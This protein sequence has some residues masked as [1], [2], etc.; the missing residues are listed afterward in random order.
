M[1]VIVIGA[2]CI[3]KDLDEVV[4]I[5]SI[6]FVIAKRC[7]DSIVSIVAFDVIISIATVYRV[8]TG[9]SEKEFTDV[10]TVCTIDGII[11]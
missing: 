8:V 10:L 6:D 7:S 5:T 4:S 1:E 3:E 11:A 2:V 9:A